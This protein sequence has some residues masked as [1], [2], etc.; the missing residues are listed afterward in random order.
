MVR[1]RLIALLAAGATVIVASP[2]SPEDWT[3]PRPR[4]TAAQT[5]IAP[6]SQL[7]ERIPDGSELI[8]LY[9][10]A[11]TVAD[12]EAANGR[13]KG[14]V[15][16]AQSVASDLA[17][18]HAA[19]MTVCEDVEQSAL[20]ATATKARSLSATLARIDGELAKSLTVMRQRVAAERLSST[21]AKDDVNRYTVAA[22]ELGRLNL[23]TQELAK[24]IHG[25][26]RNIRTAAASC[27]PT[28]IPPL[29]VEV[30]APPNKIAAIT[31]PSPTP[32][33]RPAN[34]VSKPAMIFPRY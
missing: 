26:A 1:A 32:R 10:A 22:N 19:K 12:V 30:S 25:V 28:P 34:P 11:R 13:V 17:R 18:L 24:A 31:R 16:R 5:A 4:Q 6:L 2:G 29:F 3:P 8:D 21:R 7:V 20:E 15:V 27:L 9:K 33:K 23:Q 14:E